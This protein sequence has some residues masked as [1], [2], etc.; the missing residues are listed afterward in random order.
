MASPY[1]YPSLYLGAAGSYDGDTCSGTL[2]P[3]NSTY[4][5]GGGGGTLTVS[6]VLSGANGLLVNGNVN[7]TGANTYS[8]GTTISAGM[9][10]FANGSLGTG[11]IT[12]TGAG[13]LQWAPG[14]TQDVSSQLAPSTPT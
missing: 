7:L 14:N 10:D 8:S 6:S 4:R 12:F 1:S 13:T 3:A 9:L 5:L 2:T 11:T